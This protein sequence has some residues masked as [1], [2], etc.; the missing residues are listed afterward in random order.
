M[1]ILHV[2]PH[3]VAEL[4]VRGNLSEELGRLIRL[5]PWLEALDAAAFC[6]SEDAAPPV[7]RAGARG[8]IPR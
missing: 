8:R 3:G 2:E 1:L 6:I 5:R 7:T 4:A